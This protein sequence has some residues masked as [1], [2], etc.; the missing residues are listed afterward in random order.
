MIGIIG[1]ALIVSALAIILREIG[2]RGAGIFVLVSFTVVFSFVLDGAKDVITGIF[3][4][5]SLGGAEDEMRAALKIVGT[6]YTFGVGAEACRGL[7]ESLMAKAVEVAGR[8]EILLI[9]LPFIEE[10]FSLGSELV[11]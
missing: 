10:I 5:A 2:F 1:V 8:V 9:S 6:S 3:G 4:L 7:G 11:K